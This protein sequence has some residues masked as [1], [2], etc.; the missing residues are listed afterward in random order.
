MSRIRLL[1][2]TSLYPTA[3]PEFTNFLCS[4]DGWCWHSLR[5]HFALSL[6]SYEGLFY[7]K[8]MSKSRF[9]NFLHNSMS[10][11]MSFSFNFYQHLFVWA[12]RNNKPI[13]N[14]L[15]YAWTYYDTGFYCYTYKQ[16][17]VVWW[18]DMPQYSVLSTLIVYLCDRNSASAC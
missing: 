10:L 13:T 4:M 7:A 1:L 8:G 14:L 11:I 3:G 18:S 15:R 2:F 5:G 6:H 12:R 16:N 17:I 9:K